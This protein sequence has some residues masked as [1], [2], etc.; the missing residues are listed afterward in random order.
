MAP[1]GAKG[2]KASG[3]KPPRAGK[4]CQAQGEHGRGPGVLD[5]QLGTRGFSEARDG[6]RKGLRV[7]RDGAREALR[8]TASEDSPPTHPHRSLSWALSPTE[9]TTAGGT[10]Q[11]E[12]SFL[13]KG[14]GQ[15]CWLE[16]PL[17]KAKGGPRSPSPQDGTDGAKATLRGW[18]AAR[19]GRVSLRVGEALFSEEN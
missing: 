11:P 19:G 9:A 4:S 13:G 6:G 12:A 14:R 3:G 2:K 18:G 16:D 10:T 17:L 1:D 5:Q 15:G 8:D 7:R